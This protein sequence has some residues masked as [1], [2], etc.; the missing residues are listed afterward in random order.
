MIF[1]RDLHHS[2]NSG[3]GYSMIT[4]WLDTCTI[5]HSKC[6]QGATPLPTYILD[7]S[8]NDPV[9]I[10]GKGINSQYVILSHCWGGKSTV[11]TT[12]TTEMENRVRIPRSTLPATF[13]DAAE[14]TQKLGFRYLWIDSLCIIQD[15][16]TR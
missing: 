2:P 1:L 6:Q 16:N 11:T 5:E 3:P 15:C 9:L 13:R 10:D 12:T 8:Q 4:R 14:I 7:L